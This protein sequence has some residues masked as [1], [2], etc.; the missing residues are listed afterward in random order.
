MDLCSLRPDHISAI[1][2]Y[3]Q[4]QRINTKYNE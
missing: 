2:N 4:Y 1:T 3:I